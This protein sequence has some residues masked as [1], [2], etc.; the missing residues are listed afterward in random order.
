MKVA[1]LHTYILGLE[2]V[3]EFLKLSVRSPG[4]LTSPARKPSS[5]AGPDTPT[6]R[7]TSS[8]PGTLSLMPETPVKTA[9]SEPT[10]STP[11]SSGPMMLPRWDSTASVT[12]SPRWGWW[13]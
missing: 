10:T 8:A 13:S 12:G 7:S 2:G 3:I 6:K 11:P 5:E 1:E 4:P 9:A